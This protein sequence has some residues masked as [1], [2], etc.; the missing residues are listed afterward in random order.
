[1]AS[2]KK[3]FKIIILLVITLFSIGCK[4]SEEKKVFVKVGADQLLA[5]NYD[6]IKGKTLGIVTNHTAVLS[7]GVHLVDT[8]FSKNDIKIKRLFGPEHGIRGDAPDGE[9]IVDGTDTKTGL[10]VVS[11]YGKT[12]TFNPEMLEGI[13][14]LV[15]DI[16]DIGARF[17]TYISTMYNTIKAASEFNIPILILDRPNPINGLNISGP[18]LE[19]EFKSFVGIAQIPI[20]HGMTIGELALFFNRPEILETKNIAQ[21]TV[22]ELKNWSREMFFD[23]TNLPWIKPSPNM[24]DLETALVY[25][26]ICLIEGTNVSEGRGTNKP[27]LTIGSPY[28]ESEKIIDEMDKLGISGTKLLKKQFTPVAIKGMSL[29]PKY[30]N[31]KCNGIEIKIT[32]RSQFDPIIFGINLIYTFKKLYQDKFSFRDNWID[33]LWGSSQLRE[34]INLGIEPIVILKEYQKKLDIFKEERKKFLLY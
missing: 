4:N 19:L 13:E 28:I 29:Y 9:Y 3:L 16:Q 15:F 26:G 34:Q 30:K 18:V 22:I 33:K 14:I 1:M 10:P 12:R 8:L 23:Q 6:L 17:Y 7:N 2:N 32:D 11:L 27:F 5:E 21:L 24:P 31:V 20:R 25:P